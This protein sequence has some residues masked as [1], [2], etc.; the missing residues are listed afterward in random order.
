[1]PRLRSPENRVGRSTVRSWPRAWVRALAVL[2]CA[3]VLAGACSTTKKSPAAATVGRPTKTLNIVAG[4]NFWG[5]IVSQL[6]G[7]AGSVTSVVTDPNADP[8]NYET[9]AADARAF[10]DADYV[11]LNGA[12]YDAWANKLISANPRA[13]RTVLTVANLL[14]K[15]VGDNPHFWY[16]PD[17]VAQVVNQVTADLKSVDAADA[18]YFDAQR[19]AFNTAL[20]PYNAHLAT[21]K[22]KFGG[23]PVASTESIFQYLADYLGLK[24][25]SPPDFMQA[26]AEGN[27]PPA[28]SVVAFQDLLTTKQAKVLVYNRQTS[29][30]VT[31]NLK[32][33]ATNHAIPVV[34]VTE[35]IQP[36]DARF[37]DWFGGQLVDLQNALTSGAPSGSG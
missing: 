30:V 6:A 19:A 8:H 36:A 10:A 37:Q 4:E 13:Q 7:Q 26:V 28:P 17:Y 22:T 21:I 35:T 20:G 25:V 3:S 24:V 15:K 5:S 9:S 11:V 12:G 1:M 2:G 31:S 33:I 29:T 18:G 16:R 23:T 32:Q 27:D 14:G 34:G